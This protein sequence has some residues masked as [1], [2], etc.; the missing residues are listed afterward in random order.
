MRGTIR[1]IRPIRSRAVT[2]WPVADTGAVSEDL[3]KT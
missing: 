3:L 2:D 1:R